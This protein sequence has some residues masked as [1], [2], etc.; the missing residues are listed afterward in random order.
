MKPILCLA[1]SLALS[2]PALVQADPRMPDEMM[3]GR[4]SQY[5][6][7]FRDGFREAVRMMNGGGNSG[8]GNHWG[9]GIHIL[10]AVYSSNR[11]GSCDFTRRLASQANGRNSFNFASNDGWCGDPAVGHVKY[12]NIIYSCNGREQSV[13]VRQERSTTLRCY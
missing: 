4:S 9:R 3:R 12:A 11:G 6:E 13:S 1:L 2:A 5:Q 7:G 8:G 10:S